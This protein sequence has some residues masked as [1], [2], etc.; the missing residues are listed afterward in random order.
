MELNIGEVRLKNWLAKGAEFTVIGPDLT[1]AN[2]LVVDEL[3]GDQYLY[4][5]LDL[6]EKGFGK[7]AIRQEF[8]LEGAVDWLKSVH[9]SNQLYPTLTGEEG[10]IYIRTTA[11]IKPE[12]E[13]NRELTVPMGEWLL[14]RQGNDHSI[15]KLNRK[16]F[17]QLKKQRSE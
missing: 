17:S 8:N 11:V 3:V 14:D 15:E 10:Y 5:Y 7:I 2:L 9:V 16:A 12:K 6:T 13:S 1:N 4:I